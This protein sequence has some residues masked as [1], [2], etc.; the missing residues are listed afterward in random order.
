M[1]P[2]NP[3]SFNR[4]AY[5]MGDPVNGNDPSG[6]DCDISGNN[7]LTIGDIFG[8][9]AGA[10]NSTAPSGLNN[11]AVVVNGFGG[12]LAF[13]GNSFDQAFNAMFYA[14]YLN[15]YEDPNRLAAQ[16]QQQVQ[17]IT[18]A[19]G[20]LLGQLGATQTQIDDVIDALENNGTI[21]GGHL[22]LTI[23]FTELVDLVGGDAA[24]ALVSGWPNGNRAGGLWGGLFDSLHSEWVDPNDPDNDLVEFHLDTFNAFGLPPIGLIGHGAYDVIWGNIVEGGHPQDCIDRGCAS[25]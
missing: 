5:V 16:Q 25:K 10:S 3:Q 17:S 12:E 20:N 14:N 2:R 8:C 18:D 1:N 24:L 9:N 4:Y 7:S 11:G 21:I 22:N 6:L 23:D 19:L 13:S 15:W